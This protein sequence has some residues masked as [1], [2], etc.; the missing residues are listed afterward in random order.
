[1]DNDTEKYPNGRELAWAKDKVLTDNAYPYTRLHIFEIGNYKIKCFAIVDD[2]RSLPGYYDIVVTK[3]RS[4]FEESTTY[5][6]LEQ[7][8]PAQ[9]A[10]T[11][12]LSQSTGSSSYLVDNEEINGNSEATIENLNNK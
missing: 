5:D 10:E 7:S 12:A 11:E 9:A 4:T 1:M 2:L 3:P 8:T 6:V